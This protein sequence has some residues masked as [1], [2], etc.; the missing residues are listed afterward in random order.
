MITNRLKP[1]AR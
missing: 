1:I